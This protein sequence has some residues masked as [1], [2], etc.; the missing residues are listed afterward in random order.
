MP[1]GTSP[2]RRDAGSDSTE[3]LNNAIDRL[4]TGGPTPVLNDPE[5]H[6]L[7]QL[8]VRLYNE[9]PDHLPDPAFRH[10]LKQQ[11]T[12]TRPIPVASARQPAPTPTRFPWVA[13]VSAIAAV[14]LAAVSVGSLGIWLDNDGG[15]SPGFTQMANFSGEQLTATTNGIAASTAEA[16]LGNRG[17][18]LETIVPAD[19]TS[20]TTTQ[21]AA[22]ETTTAEAT[23]ETD[24]PADPTPTNAVASNQAT[25]LAATS[26]PT[27]GTALAAVPPV[28][29]QHV[30]QGPRPAADGSSGTPPADVDYVLETSLPDLIDDAQVYRLT[31]PKVDPET[32]V[33]RVADALGMEGDIVVDAPMGRTIYHLFDEERG[34]FHWTPETGAFTIAPISA[35]TGEPMPFDQVVAAANDWLAEIGYP[36]GQLATD[37]EAVP[38]GDSAWRLDTRYAAMPEVGLGHPLGVSVFI[39]DDGT[40][41]EVTGYWLE[42]KEVDSADL[43]SADAIWQAVRSGHGLWTGGG[44]VEGGGEFHADAMTITYLLTRDPSGDLV[45][46]PVVETTGDF[47]TPDGLSSARVSCYIQAARTTEDSAP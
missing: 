40:V 20:M 41:S 17:K 6:D 47:T 33:H 46:Q 11:L 4:M 21:P 43:H 25:N 23:I 27:A 15:D 31:P 28:D 30:E 37:V 8:A 13:A 12:T 16:N 1:D 39:N 36:V 2:I 10:D 35:A 19:P 18:T 29:A 32:F 5:L 34:S 3:R 44:I 45:L 9:L 22:D 42:V 14:M 26:E 38:V 7:L 24:P